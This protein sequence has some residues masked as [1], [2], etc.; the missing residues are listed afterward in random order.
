MDEAGVKEKYTVTPSQFVD[1]KA[2]TGDASDN[3]P[4]VSGIGPKTASN[5][6]HEYGNVENIYKHL[7]DIAVKNKNLAQKL[8]DGA[9]SAELGKKLAQIVLDVPFVCEFTDCRT[10]GIDV[11]AFKKSLEEFEFKTLPQR[12]E[13][14]FVKKEETKM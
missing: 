11:N 2:L 8:I 12:V 14:V 5:L 1:L 10:L 7:D 13:E 3:Y 9:E 4:G 6:I